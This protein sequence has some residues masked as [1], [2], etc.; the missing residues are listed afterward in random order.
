L[1]VMAA[2]IL[3]FA[4]VFENEILIFCLIG[5]GAILA[6]KY[7]PWQY[8]FGNLILIAL[9]TLIFYVFLMPDLIISS[10]FVKELVLNLISGALIFAFLNFLWQNK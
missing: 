9:G 4:P 2:L 3:K 8:F 6:K 1:V 10:V 7:L 5:A